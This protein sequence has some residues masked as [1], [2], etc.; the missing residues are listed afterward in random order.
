MG[1][2]KDATDALAQSILAQVPMKRFGDPAEVASAVAFF[3]SPD[4]SYV[5][6]AELRVGGGIGEL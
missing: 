6:G 2:P 5:T 3:A 4:S 1:L